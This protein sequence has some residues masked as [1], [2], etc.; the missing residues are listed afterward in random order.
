MQ[1][2]INSITEA[3]VCY[4]DQAKIEAPAVLVTEQDIAR[5]FSS[6]LEGNYGQ[7]QAQHLSVVV[8]RLSPFMQYV[9]KQLATRK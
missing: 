2:A 8:A 7:I 1:R 3:V 5:A 9:E 4:H 6:I